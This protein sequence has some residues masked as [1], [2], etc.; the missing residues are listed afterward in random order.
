MTH[1]SFGNHCTSPS[2]STWISSKACVLP[3]GSRQDYVLPLQALKPMVGAT[4]FLAHLAH[5]LEPRVG[6]SNSELFLG[7]FWE[8]LQRPSWPHAR[9]TW[10]HRD[11]H[12]E[13]LGLCR[14]AGFMSVVCTRTRRESSRAMCVCQSF[15]CLCYLLLQDS[16]INISR[17]GLGLVL[18]R[19]ILVGMMLQRTEAT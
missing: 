6:H 8:P 19:R 9:C 2:S 1:A 18:P 7:F 16:S 4:S 3:S 15:R 13:L 17:S 11:T 12:L 10:P 14:S 5:G